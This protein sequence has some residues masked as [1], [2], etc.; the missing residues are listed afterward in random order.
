MANQF[1]QDG[2]HTVTIL[3]MNVAGTMG[4]ADAFPDSFTAAGGEILEQEWSVRR[5]AVVCI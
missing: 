4:M 3:N 2:I 1:Y 5:T